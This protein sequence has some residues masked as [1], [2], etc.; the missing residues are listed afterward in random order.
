MTSDILR[1][2]HK[3]LTLIR[4][5]DTETSILGIMNLQ[6]TKHIFVYLWYQ[7]CHTGDAGT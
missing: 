5:L 1:D 2:N 6:L 4:H 7:C 3:S